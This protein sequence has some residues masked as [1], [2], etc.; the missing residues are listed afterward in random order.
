MLKWVCPQLGKLQN[1]LIAVGIEPI[2]VST[3]TDADLI[4]GTILYNGMKVPA[5]LLKLFL[6]R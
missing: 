4:T 1:C 6:M 3:H 5:I 2:I